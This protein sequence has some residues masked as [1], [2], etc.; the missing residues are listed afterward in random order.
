MQN[1]KTPKTI[2]TVTQPSILPCTKQNT[3]ITFI[4]PHEHTC[5]HQSAE[6]LVHQSQ[7][8]TLAIFN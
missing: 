7:N 8:S 2:E 5:V 1:G 6:T 4:L 3:A